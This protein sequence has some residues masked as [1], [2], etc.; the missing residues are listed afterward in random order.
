MRSTDTVYGFNYDGS[1]GTSGLDVWHHH[2]HGKMS[3]EV[4]RGKDYFPEWNTARWWLSHEA[5]QRDPARFSA[6]FE[7]GLAVFAA[8][9]IQVMPILFN[10]W[11]DPFCDFGGV[12]LDHL[13][14]WASAWTRADDLFDVDRA[15]TREAA[16]VEE[17]FER[18]VTE[19][20]GPHADDDRITAWDL[21]NEPL[22]GSYVD[23][24]ESP[25]RA[26]ELRWLQWTADRVRRVGAAQPLTIGNYAGLT[27][28]E[29]T[30]PF[31]DII[32]FH[33]YY[34]WN[35]NEAQ[36]HMSTKEGFEDFLDKACALAEARGKG[37]IA[38]E[39]VWGARNHAT[40][41]EVLNYTLEQLVSRGIGFTV[42]ALHHSLIADLHRDEYGPVGRPEWMHF[43]DPDG[44]LRPGHGAFN[45]F[46][47]SKRRQRP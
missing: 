22:M 29:L 11:R 14:P 15:D 3:V 34:M 40:H 16:P 17:L 45:D 9:D 1:W 6:N 32:S 33:P 4:A 35:G 46:A 42:H 24:P 38:S 10:R 5:F 23:E 13:L 37:L 8:H 27:A 21:C 43:I 41:V 26:A 12:P 30:E 47:P 2:D 28:L 44:S 25:I 39:T 31:T 36:P 19:V 7:A 18:Y 20:V